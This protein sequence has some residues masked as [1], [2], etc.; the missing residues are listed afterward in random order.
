MT[1]EGTIA[2]TMR[3]RGSILL[4]GCLFCGQAAASP[5]PQG[6]KITTSKYNVDM[7]DGPVLSSSRVTALA[8]AY[9]PLAD[10]V[11]GL[12]VNPA[13]PAVRAPY[14]YSHFDYDV[15]LGFTFPSALA[16]TDFDNNGTTG[17]TYQKFVF[18]TMGALVQIGQWGFGANIDA[19]TYDL[20]QEAAP[21]KPLSVRLFHAHAS[22]ARNFFDA[23]LVVG[24][25]FRFAGLDL[26]TTEGSTTTSLLSMLGFAGEI[27]AVLAPHAWPFRLG[28]TARSP[29]SGGVDPNSAA[30]PDASGELFLAG[31]YLPERVSLPWEIE[32]GGAWQL[33]RPINPPWVDPRQVSE[34]EV[35]AATV[36]QQAAE[37]G[38]P[39]D[40]KRWKRAEVVRRMLKA[41]YESLP[42]ER[43]L[44]VAALKI[45]GPVD[46]AV[47]VESFLAQVV[48]RSGRHTSFTPRLG[49]EGEPLGYYLQLRLGTYL[50]PTRFDV[51]DGPRLHGTFGFDVRVLTWDVFGLFD[52]GT[53]F[54]VGGMVDGARRYFGWGLTAGIFH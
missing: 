49:L 19:R 42:R 51:N 45:S 36:G 47:G 44:V 52:E 39:T 7:F 22:L 1:V 35:N 10:G 16:A 46:D 32:L 37:H 18:F 4:A 38:D 12:V 2:P 41:R 6:S 17:F 15:S 30:K 26:T 40:K 25:G 11:E 34:A 3:L 13:A 24:L 23:Q 54:R 43:L 9:V 28:F 48:D 27:G 14:S 33:G 5:D 50:E 53:G 21:G 31:K 29:V 8:G 20:E